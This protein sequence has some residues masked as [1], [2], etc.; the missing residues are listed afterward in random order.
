M[1]RAPGGALGLIGHF[2][3]FQTRQV[4]PI[5]RP[6]LLVSERLLRT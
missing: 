5:P 6:P 3:T 1:K 4:P 2:D